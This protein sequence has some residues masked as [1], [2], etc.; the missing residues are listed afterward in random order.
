LISA[1]ESL[2]NSS[3]QKQGLN[4][5]KLAELIIERQIERYTSVENIRKEN[6]NMFLAAKTDV[7]FT[8]CKILLN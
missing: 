5:R 3:R 1:K 6:Y 7:R 4:S 8:S 2:A